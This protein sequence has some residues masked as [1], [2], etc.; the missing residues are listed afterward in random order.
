MVNIA[1]HIIMILKGN[2][3]P[4]TDISNNWFVR[5]RYETNNNLIHIVNSNGDDI[6]NNYDKDNNLIRFKIFI[7]MK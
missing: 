4:F 6:W 3:L 2:I 7:N 5:N 1:I